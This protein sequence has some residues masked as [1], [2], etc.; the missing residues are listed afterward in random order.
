GFS[1]A[2]RERA[3]AGVAVRIIY[4]AVGCLNTPG[5]FFAELQY[6]G[7]ELIEYRPLRPWHKRFG[8]NTR[9]HRKILVVDTAVGFTGGLHI[10]DQ[11]A[12]KSDGG[13]GW[14]D[15]H[16]QVDGP[17]VSDL[18]RLFRRVWIREGGSHYPLPGPDDQPRPGACLARVVDN[19]QFRHRRKLH[20]AY[21]RAINRAEERICLMNAYFIPDASIRRALCKAAQRGVSVRII[22]PRESDVSIMYYASQHIYGRLIKG[23]I[24]ILEWP[25]TMMHAKIAVIDSV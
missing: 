25:E 5:S 14:H 21:L 10:S 9:D 6:D 13:E 7:A 8:L 23:G 3:R 22:V 4:D 1:D 12:P 17:I 24:E 19:R 18:A 15:M 16:C 11:Y 20:R 2:L